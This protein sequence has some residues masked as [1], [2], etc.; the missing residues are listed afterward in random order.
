MIPL[1]DIKNIAAQIHDVTGGAP[2][3]ALREITLILAGYVVSTPEEG[4]ATRQEFEDA[5][6]AGL[7]ISRAT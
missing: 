1:A 6:A 3:I 4:G 7:R 5:W 2:H